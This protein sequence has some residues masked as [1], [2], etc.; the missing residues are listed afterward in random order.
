MKKQQQLTEGRSRSMKKIIIFTCHCGSGHTAVNNALQYYLSESYHVQSV[1]IFC[2]V[3]P[4]TDLIRKATFNR[5]NLEDFY[6][7][8]LQK[9]WNQFLNVSL[10]INHYY[11]RF[12]YKKINYI[13]YTYLKKHRPD[14]VISIIPLVNNHILNNTEKLNIPFI[15]FPTDLSPGIFICNIKKINHPKFRLAVSFEDNAILESF[16]LYKIPLQYINVTGFPLKPNFF[17]SKYRDLFKNEFKIP[18]NKSVVLLLM[19]SQG[20]A[21]LYNFAQQLA[22]INIP[23]HLIIVRGKNGYIHKKISDIPFP[24]HISTTL[25]GFTQRIYDLMTITDLLITKSGGASV[26][27]AIYMNVPMLLDATSAVP[28]WEQLN[29]NFVVKHNF[30]EIIKKDNAIPGLVIKYLADKKLLST[31]KQNLKSYKKKNGGVEIKK[32]VDQT[33]Y[34]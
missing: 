17:A 31:I 33:L 9:K 7:F 1:C 32:L 11:L 2:E 3:L 12:Q 26:C 4:K 25:L 29:Q 24:P 30:G 14:L 22:T 19:G 18:K 21:S 13:I 15:L 34:M 5:Y 27:E 28:Q 23:F 10:Q 8:L 20:A 16:N 6:N